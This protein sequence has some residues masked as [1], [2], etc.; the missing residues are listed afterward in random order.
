[1]IDLLLMKELYIADRNLVTLVGIDFPLYVE[2]LWCNGNQL[3]SLHGCPS[4]VRILYCNDNQLTSLDGC[5]PNV[6]KLYCN[7][8]RLTSLRDCPSSIKKLYCNNNPLDAEYK[9]KTLEQIHQINRFKA[10][11]KG[12]L[13]L[14][15]TIYPTRIQRW[16]KYHYYDKLDSNGLSLFCLRSIDDSRNSGIIN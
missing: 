7:F 14:N 2:I 9:N 6:Q 4:T 13:K 8:N 5:P 3:T 15:S 16:W 1:M 12:I 10:F 11:Q